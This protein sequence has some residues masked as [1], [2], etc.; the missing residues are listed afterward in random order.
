MGLGAGMMISREVLGKP[1]LVFRRWG[2]GRERN[3]CSLLRLVQQVGRYLSLCL[4]EREPFACI[5]GPYLSLNSHHPPLKERESAH[6]PAT[7]GSV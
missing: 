6:S 2:K 1:F 3:G 5:R 4:R 7:A